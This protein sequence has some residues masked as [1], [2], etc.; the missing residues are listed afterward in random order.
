MCSAD[1][2][3]S[4]DEVDDAYEARLAELA[5][6]AK[7][8]K[9][10]DDRL[11]NL[12]AVTFFASIAGGIYGLFSA[13]TVLWT[14]VAAIFSVFLFFVVLHAIVATRQFE[15]DRR[16][17]IIKRGLERVAGGFRAP[18][19]EEHVRGD[20]FVDGEHPYTSDLDVFG[21]ASLFEQLNATRTPGGAATLATWLRRPASPDVVRDRQ[22][23]VRELAGMTTLREEMALAG[24]RAGK[25][26]RD[27]TSFLAWTKEEATFYKRGTLF[28]ALSIVMVVITMGIFVAATMYAGRLWTIYGGALAV[29][30]VFLS[31][32][33]PRV[34][35]VLA[36]VCI[37]QSPLGHYRDLL[38]AAEQAELSNGLLVKL[39]NDLKVEGALASEKM[40]KLDN[41]VGLAAVRHNGFVHILADI[42]LLWDVWC[43]WL[44]DRWRAENGAKVAVWLDT[45]AELEALVSL[46]TFAYEHPAYA[47][48]EIVDRDDGPRYEARDLGHPLIARSERI[49]NDIALT[50]TMSGL[51]ITGSNM[52]GKST[53]LRS[54]GINSVLAQAG[55][56]VCA[57]ELRLSSVSLYT[58]MRIGDD[59][60]RGASRFFME[61]AK[62]DTIVKALKRRTPNSPALCFLLDEVL[63]G[64]NSRERNIGAKA[65]VRYLIEQGALGVVSSHDL[66][67]VELEALTEGRV[68]NVHFEDHIENDAMCFDYRMKPGP[69]STS[70]A[71]RLMRMVG[72][73][74]PGLD[75]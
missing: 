47:Y 8:L 73:D 12:R 41:L 58:S 71:L 6:V 60:D 38:A 40:R 30:I 2:K 74:V 25:L 65:V 10:R 44:V 33:R 50:P 48:P 57:S 4:R 18:K 62:L 63:H 56:P 35:P 14:V 3:D 37:K 11:S 24:M 54:I 52:S 22:A 43:A 19:G 16:V 9:G 21:P 29:Q 51:M 28:A 20:A 32:M 46:A 53:M 75:S 61:V 7:E 69:V 39:Q 72:I 1:P 49:V 36:R 66:G 13:S 27:A 64:T 15:N 17:S 31:L 34:E 55:A 5:D 70:N 45:L 68:K 59:L 23:A 26:D 67:L 42:F